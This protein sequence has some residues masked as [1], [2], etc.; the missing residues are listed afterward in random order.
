MKKFFKI[1]G[2]SFLVLLIL[3]I[4]L[5]F[6]FKGKLIEIAKEQINN[7]LN[8]KVAFGDFD[9]R[10]ISTFPNFTFEINDVTVDG[11]DDFDGIRLASI[12]KTEFTLDL[13]SV[14]SG[15]KVHIK[16]FGMTEPEM[17]VIVLEDG[18]ANW[19]IVKSDGEAE[20]EEVVEE[21]VEDEEPFDLAN[22]EEYFFKDVKLIYDDRE[23]NMYA[24]IIGLTHTG[25][26][27]FASNLFIFH[28]NTL[29]DELTYKMDGI[30]YLNRSNI[31]TKIDIEMNMDD[32]K[33]TFM[34]NEFRLNDL[35]L[36]FDGFLAMP[37]DDIDMD[38]TFGADRTDFKSI[39]SLVP[40]VYMTDFADVQTDGNL[41]LNGFVRGTYS[42]EKE[43][44][45]GFDLDLAV[46]NARFAYPD[47]P[48]SVE[49]I[50][51]KL[52]M[53]SEG[54]YEY[55]DLIIDLS[56]FNME[57]AK[58]QIAMK[59]YMTNPITDPHFDFDLKSQLNL[60]NL[61]EVI[62]MEEGESYNGDFTADIKL[63]G[64]LSAIEQE[65]YDDFIAKGNLILLDMKY[66]TE[67]LP[68]AI[69]IS[70]LYFT[71]APEKLALT[72]FDM[73]LGNSDLQANGDIK[74]YM[75]YLF[76]ENETLGG[77]FNVTSTY[78]NLNE[79]MPES[80]NGEPVA[81]E[82]EGDT[83]EYELSV[84]EIPANIDFV[85]TSRFNELI[86]DDIDM[87][88]VSGEIMLRN[89]AA[90]LT[91]LRMDIL[92]GQVIMSGSYDT[93]DA[94]APLT[95]FYFDIKDMDIKKTAE[96]FNTVEKMAPIASKTTGKFSAGMSFKATLDEKMDPVME[97]ISGDGRL[98][99][100]NI[101]IEGFEPLNRLAEQLKMDRFK[102]QN[103]EDVKIR[104]EF[105]D[106]R[107]NVEPYD[108]KLGNSKATIAGYTTFDQ[109]MNYVMQMNIPR[110]EF[111]SEANKMLE[112]LLADAA[113]KG[114]EVDPGS[115]VKADILIKGTVDDPKVTVSLADMGKD[116]V[117]S[118]KDQIKDK[119]DEKVE[120]V[121][122]KAQE[123]LNKRADQVVAEAEKRAEQIRSEGK[124]GAKK[125]RDEGKSAADK[126]RA[127]ANRQADN[128]EAEASNP[129]ERAA[130]KKAAD[131]VRYEGKKKADKAESEA[132]TR[133]NRVE[134]EAN[135]RADKI[136]SEA[137][138]RADR[139]RKGEEE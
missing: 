116:L 58:N 33:F 8:A 113:K 102:K 137:N 85:M 125:I 60:A 10:F 52:K 99:A 79:L 64:A 43:L 133:A 119:V 53:T 77:Q 39:L 29:I 104:F 72:T 95:D 134:K 46:D 1:F 106:G 51:V 24:E 4:T 131:K 2:I 56:K 20:E 82:T 103:I 111:G 50:A 130:A 14:I 68:Y 139:I 87:K 136:I 30:K 67:D 129:F 81:E 112:G 91:D 22:L 28:T 36:S 89:Q 32:F 37:E 44:M 41:A 49:N 110:S 61:K 84:I 74:N 138:E 17:H 78:F 69:D 27:D 54:K 15:D 21:K 71:F 35:F 135:D 100:K 76:K 34:E 96:T 45:P 73:K 121:K 115:T 7:Q 70:K 118:V 66:E 9:L 120:E 12:K 11:I 107:V 63:K 59:L 62:P 124:R 122:D 3:L 26:G 48:Q 55:D 80:E 101:F 128:I 75:G 16:S 47:M 127:E 23:G 6:L 132:N 88:N 5:P 90:T 109:K 123:E 105:K 57:I 86:F 108:V 31:E 19:D 114:V 126:I 98:E 97:T 117:G 13:M 38:I 94:T 18:K 93:K 83:E 25:S 92:E 40:A 42:E 65:R